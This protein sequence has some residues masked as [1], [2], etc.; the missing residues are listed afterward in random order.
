[1]P[2]VTDTRV[3]LEGIEVSKTIHD[4]LQRV[5][6]E[7]VKSGIASASLVFVHPGGMWGDEQGWHKGA[8]IT[9][10]L[11]GHTGEMT[12]VFDGDIT[13]LRL[14][15]RVGSS[16]ELEVLASD[17]LHLLRR[18]QR[19]KVYLVTT[20]TD[21][22]DSL[23]SGTGLTGAVEEPGITYPSIIRGGVSALELLQERAARLG[24]DLWADGDTVHLGST[25]TG[26]G[27]V[28]LTWEEDLISLSITRTAARVPAGV[29]VYGWDP[30]GKAQWVGEA[31]VGSEALVDTAG[32][33]A[34]T[35]VDKVFSGGATPITRAPVR[36]LKEA[37]AVAAGLLEDGSMEFAVARGAV[38]G[39]PSLQPGATLTLA[40]AP[41][42]GDGPWRVTWVQHTHDLNG[43]VTEFEAQR[44]S[45]VAP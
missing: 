23:L 42:P 40:H 43:F 37:E 26:A 7:K 41:S 14:R 38:L 2:I 30:S 19:Q 39:L 15:R 5:R 25:H 29:D 22:L 32:D 28:T 36:S 45:G 1:M 6:V 17:R 44:N 33:R 3:A 21:L 35:G 27:S 20:E 4:A 13:G 10:S 34:T 31:A 11:K 9:I 16:V 18:D 8:E 24:Y 12:E